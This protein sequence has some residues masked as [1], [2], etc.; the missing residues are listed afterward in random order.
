[1]KLSSNAIITE[2][3]VKDY[4]LSQKKEMINQNG[5]RRQDITLM[6]GDN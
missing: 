1:M 3:K 2:D 4:L 6:I 5:L